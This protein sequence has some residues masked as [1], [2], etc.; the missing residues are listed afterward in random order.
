MLAVGLSKQTWQGEPLRTLEA[1]TSEHEVP[2]RFA[3]ET[4]SLATSADPWP[5]R[6]LGVELG[7][8]QGQIRGPNCTSASKVV[9]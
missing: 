6:K 7:C 9:R 3:A 1:E 8:F 4:V 2:I 5:G